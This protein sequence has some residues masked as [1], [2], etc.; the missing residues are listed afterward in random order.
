M[1]DSTIVTAT[2][3]ELSAA[4][5]T[6]TFPRIEAADIISVTVNGQEANKDGYS[7]L[8]VGVAE[9]YKDAEKYGFDGTENKVTVK[10]NETYTDESG[11]SGTSVDVEKEFNFSYVTKDAEHFIMFEDDPIIY[12]GLG[13]EALTPSETVTE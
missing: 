12:R 8:S 1:I 13:I 10:Y 7:S 5:D 9:D 11:A 6:Q 3:Y 4:L 2:N